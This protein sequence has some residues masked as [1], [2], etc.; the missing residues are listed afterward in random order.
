M[1]HNLLQGFGTIVVRFLYLF[2]LL[3]FSTVP[4]VETS[5]VKGNVGIGVWLALLLHVAL[6]RLHK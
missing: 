3:K 6:A 5:E 2:N 4:F 1:S